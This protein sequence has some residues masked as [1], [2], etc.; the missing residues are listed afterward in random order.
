MMLMPKSKFWPLANLGRRL[1]GGGV[2]IPA[3]HF[4]ATS[5]DDSKDGLSPATAW[6]TITKCN[7]AATTN[8]TYQRLFKRG[9]T[10][11][12]LIYPQPNQKFGNYGSGALPKILG[13]AAL[14]TG[15]GSTWA[16]L[17]STAAETGSLDNEGFEGSGSGGYQ[18][19][20]TE[21]LGA[22]SVLDEANQDVARPT[23][24]GSYIL[25]AQKVSANYNALA[26]RN[27]G[28]QAAITYTRVYVY[29]AAEGLADT[30][31]VVLVNEQDSAL[32]DVVG[33]KLKQQTGG[34]YTFDFYVYTN[35]AYGYAG[36]KTG[37][38]LN[39]WYKLEMLY[40]ATNAKFDFRVDGTSALG[41]LQN[42]TGTYKTGVQWIRLG[43]AE[44]SRTVT[45]YYDREACDATH[46]LADTITAPANTWKSAYA[47]APDNV[48]FIDTDGTTIHWGNKVASVAAIANLYD[49]YADG[50]FLYVNS[51]GATAGYNPNT[52]WSSVEASNQSHCFW[53]SPNNYT[54]VTV[55]GFEMAFAS[56]VGISGRSGWE[57]KNNV[58]HHIG[59]NSGTND[60]VGAE[61][62]GGSN[63][64]IHHNTIYEVAHYGIN[65][66]SW[67]PFDASNNLIEHNSVY[68]CGVYGIALQVGSQPSAQSGNIVRY[69]A[70]YWDGTFSGN[71]ATVRGIM[72]VSAAG[73]QD[74]QIYYNL[75]YGG[76]QYGI[77][78]STL[79]INTLL[80]NNVIKAGAAQGI[81]VSGTS[82][83][84]IVLKNNIVVDASGY[85][86]YIIDSTK[87]AACDN[88]CWYAPS[89]TGYAHVNASSYSSAQFATYKS[90]TGF[91]A[92]GKWENPLVVGAANFHLQAGSP[93]INTGVS[94][95][96]ALD[97]AGVAVSDPPEMGAY[98]F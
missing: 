64:W 52:V 65:V 15:A 75:I 43:D 61:I 44:N 82:T 26:K 14:N 60:A 50:S 73:A 96:L 70:I 56:G 33:V 81:Y 95:G 28:A 30:Q 39:Q 54:N 71:V 69:N 8:P 42:L 1:A 55:D 25:K 10:F 16:V 74:A 5:G 19:I 90:D 46:W 86:L 87:I 68:N 91:D 85:A 76:P 40:D 27:M 67:N 21:V 37:I 83:S 47:A 66:N 58:I 9:E 97:Y 31:N 38:N 36:Q 12:G 63:G 92:H 57:I 94:V 17:T 13:S 79:T 6:K 22:G 77:A 24:G 18:E 2:P 51:G 41:G 34:A 3:Y 48:W 62:S 78:L 89:G 35:G 11:R 98:E 53:W 7:A 88:N 4:D 29:I 45:V 32:A 84:G 80:Y 20:W 23:D 49:W 72:M 59:I 93:C